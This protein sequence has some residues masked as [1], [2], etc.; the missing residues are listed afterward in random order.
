MAMHNDIIIYNLVHAALTH[1]IE[2]LLGSISIKFKLIQVASTD[3][4]VYLQLAL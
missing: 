1:S 4:F 3:S 2:Q